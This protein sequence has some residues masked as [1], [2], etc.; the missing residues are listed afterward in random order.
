MN[1]GSTKRPVRRVSLCQRPGPCVGVGCHYDYH[2]LRGNVL[3]RKVRL[4]EFYRDTG[5]PTERQKSFEYWYREDPRNKPWIWTK[6]KPPEADRWLYHM[7]ELL[8]ALLDNS[9]IVVCEGEKDADAV[10]DVWGLPATTHH[11]GGTQ[12]WTAEQAAWWAWAHRMGDPAAEPGRVYIAVDRDPTGYV[13]AWRTACALR[14]HGR[15]NMRRITFIWPAVKTR[16]AD[17]SDH[18]S[19]GYGPDQVIEISAD[20]VR[21][22]HDE[23]ASTISRG[24]PR[25]GSGP[26]LPGQVLAELKWAETAWSRGEGIRRHG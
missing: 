6:A 5:E 24:G 10:R 20:I 1:N 16:H 17:I 4:N 3:F 8:A 13:H 26:W 15:M 2:D 23:Y 14:D 7:P 21:R 22:R 18:I 11:Q 12:P 9:D 19:A 25:M